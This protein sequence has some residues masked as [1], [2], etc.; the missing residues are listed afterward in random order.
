[1]ASTS[2]RQELEQAVAGSAGGW[3]ASGVSSRKR[4]AEPMLPSGSGSRS[5]SIQQ[6]RK[7]TKQEHLVTS[8]HAVNAFGRDQTGRVLFKENSSFVIC[9][10]SGSGKTTFI[11]HLLKNASKMFT[12]DKDREIFILYCYA[13]TQPLFDKMEEDI[14]NI[15]FHKGLPDDDEIDEYTAPAS[16]HLILVVD[17]L[18]RQVVTSQI[19][20]DFFTVKAH[21]QGTSVVYVSHN[22]YQQGKFSRAITLNAAYFI[23]FENP[24]G[25]DQIQ[26]LSRQIFPGK[27]DAVVQ[28]YRHAMNLKSFSYLVL[29]MTANVPDM[30]RM[31]SSIF[32]N[33][34]TRYFWF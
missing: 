19:I 21:H 8:S 31:R 12:N 26:T 20:F 23:L 30:L 27:K 11:Y 32:P 33:A 24:R 1:M 34:H 7:R 14:P 9:G 22:L 2:S 15:A 17:D 13:S 16:R 5:S 3:A 6:G 29:D 28:A 25:A 4:K 10:R 18:M